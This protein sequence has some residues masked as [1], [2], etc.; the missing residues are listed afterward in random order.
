MHEP[1]GH[2][3]GG[4][5]APEP[6]TVQGTGVVGELEIID[7]PEGERLRFRP[8]QALAAQEL[9]VEIDRPGHPP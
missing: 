8:T 9:I 7:T 1:D 3:H 4:H 2:G 6:V 5:L